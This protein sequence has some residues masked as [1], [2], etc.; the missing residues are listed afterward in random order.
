MQLILTSKSYFRTVTGSLCCLLLKKPIQQHCKL[1][2]AVWYNEKEG[3]PCC[4][5]Q[6][7]ELVD[8]FHIIWLPLPGHGNNFNHICPLLPWK[9]GALDASLCVFWHGLN[10]QCSTRNEMVQRLTCFEWYQCICLGITLAEAQDSTIVDCGC[11][12]PHPYQGCNM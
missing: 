11:T 6:E 10:T 7:N 12:L 4:C 3:S 9:C 8:P 1:E 5:S 2:G